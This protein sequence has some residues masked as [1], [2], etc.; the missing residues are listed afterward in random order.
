MLTALLLLVAALW[1][2][3]FTVVKDAVAVYGVVAFPAVR[4]A[5]A[6]GALGN[7]KTG[8]ESLARRLVRC[9]VA[10]VDAMRRRG[11]ETQ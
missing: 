6:S 8:R 2:W 1:G 7:G 5:I 3:T 11:M 4:F 9:Q 10:A